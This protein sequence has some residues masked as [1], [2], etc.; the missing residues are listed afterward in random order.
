MITLKKA[1]FL[2]EEK[3]SDFE[4]TSTFDYKDKYIFIIVPKDFDV[5]KDIAYIDNFHSVDKKTGG[6]SGFAPW[7]D[8]EFLEQFS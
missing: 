1:E 3:F 2:I 8:T 7:S 5:D 4:I 6:I